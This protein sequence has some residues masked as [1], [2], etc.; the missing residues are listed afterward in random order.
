M[1]PKWFVGYT[2][3]LELIFA[4]VTLC[5][6][7][8]AFKVYKITKEREPKLFSIGFLS[9]FFS[10]IIWF[11]L[12][13]VALFELNESTEAL[14]I[15]TA[16]SLINLGAYAHLFFFMAGIITLTYTT[17]EIKSRRALAMISSIIFI[18]IILSES[19]T[20][21]FY[22]ISAVLIL[23][24]AVNYLIKYKVNNNPRLITMLTAFFFLFISMFELA[25]S[26][27]N[28]THF[29]IGHVFMF[30]AYFLILINL[31]YV[32]NHGQKKKQT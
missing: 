15:G 9:I 28:R 27:N 13:L 3:G 8:L 17:L 20:V 31:G 1:V 12:N 16:I 24:L 26:V 29:V 5:V 22:S 6:S 2:L 7:L 4:I 23:F 10:Y 18:V 11:A 21:L 25:L 32:L 19:K 30:V 14:N